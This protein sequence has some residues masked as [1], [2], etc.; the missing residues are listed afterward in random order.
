[1]GGGSG[2][3]IFMGL[4]AAV[5]FLAGIRD[6]RERERTR[7]KKLLE[8][9]GRVSDKEMTPERYRQ[10]QGYLKRH[11]REGQI[12][13]VTWNDL[14]MDRLYHRMDQ[15]ASGCGEEYLYYLLH[16]PILDADQAFYTK[17][18]L[19]FPAKDPDKRVR[20]QEILSAIGTE[21]RYSIYDYLDVLDQAQTRPAL[22][23]ILHALAVPLSLALILVQT[24][25]GVICF[26]LVIAINM[27]TYFRDKA[28][29]E[30][31]LVTMKYILRLIGCAERLH[32][33]GCPVFDRDMEELGEALKVLAPFKKGSALI[34]A[35]A[36]A[37]SGSPL[38]ILLDYM[39]Y[40]THADLWK[41][42]RMLSL[43]RG[44]EDA[45]DT[46]IRVCGRIDT[47][48]S[49][50][51]FEQTLPRACRPVFAG[52]GIFQA[53]DMG[54]PLLEDPVP[55]S[56]EAEGPLLVTGSNASGKS[57]FLKACALS[58]LLAQTAGIVPASSY[59][60]GLFRIFSSMALRDDLQAGESYFVV[61][62]RSLK[63]ILDAAEE[64]GR[65]VL[66]CI[67]EVLRGTNT[68]ERIAASAE[69]LKTLAGAGALV[70]AATH[71]IE[72]TRLLEK[73][74]TNY[75]FEEQV[76]EEGV[77]F[78]YRLL[79]GPSD[80]RNAILLLS[81]MGFDPSLTDRAEK[82]AASFL[83]TGVW[84]TDE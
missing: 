72:L 27:V 39:R 1:M 26:L 33:E 77:A 68:V 23:H 31:H 75:H 59:E 9:F 7:R 13:E 60:S 67:D 46:L 43:A 22:A 66:C 54:H 34:A 62:I 47:C 84:E 65:P 41:F 45:I 36:G 58:A 20:I 17:A 38:D 49:L 37:G 40:L 81:A 24:Q 35:D 12:D 21:D 19:D 55:N 56:L 51:S 30:P 78:S 53:K 50:A 48:V 3:L 29:I 63:R 76:T 57:T 44:R 61:E 4:F 11:L 15:S 14:D 18:Q 28:K 79:N 80:T 42:S 10:I 5:F 16:S 6:S 52:D 83:K 70:L 64:P 74:Y 25:V 73:D 69:I 82:R 8:A 32:K 2:I 71:D